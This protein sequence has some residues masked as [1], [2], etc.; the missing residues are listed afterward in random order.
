VFGYTKLSKITALLI[1]RPLTFGLASPIGARFEGRFGARR[2]AVTGSVAMLASMMLFVLT[3]TSESVPLLIVA[4][5]MSGL[6]FG[7]VT[8]PISNGTDSDRS[9]EHTSELQSL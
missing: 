9:E 2:T 5:A 6:S 7:L 3:T 4:L 1:L 8:A